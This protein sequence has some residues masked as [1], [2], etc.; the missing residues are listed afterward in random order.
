MRNSIS[1]LSALA[2]TLTVSQALAQTMRQSTK[3]KLIVVTGGISDSGRREGV[4]MD[5]SGIYLGREECEAAGAGIK[6]GVVSAGGEGQSPPSITWIC[7]PLG[8]P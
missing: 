8:K 4:A 1:V 5:G 7:V 2:L 6:F 3:Y